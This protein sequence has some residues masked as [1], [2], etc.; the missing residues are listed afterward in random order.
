MKNIANNYLLCQDYLNS[1]DVNGD[2]AVEVTQGWYIDP[3]KCVHWY[4]VSGDI[5]RDCFLSKL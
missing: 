4:I 1:Y 3:L 2:C 5:I